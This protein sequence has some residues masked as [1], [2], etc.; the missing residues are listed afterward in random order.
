M[1]M[2]R[3]SIRGWTVKLPIRK[4]KN[5][6]RCITTVHSHEFNF[7]SIYRGDTLLRSWQTLDFILAM[8]TGGDGGNSISRGLVPGLG[9]NNRLFVA[10]IA[11]NHP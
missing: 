2:H 8:T 9:L 1:H 6:A 10:D 7:S 3:S 11:P 5:L 4:F